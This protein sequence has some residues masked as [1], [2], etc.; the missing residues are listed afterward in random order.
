MILSFL[1]FACGLI[2]D[3]V[4]RGRVE[5]KRLSYLSVP[6]RFTLSRKGG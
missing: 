6:V 2:L 1:A 5:M 3:T 4:S